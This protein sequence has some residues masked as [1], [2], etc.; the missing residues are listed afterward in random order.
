MKNRVG[1][2]FLILICVGLTIGLIMTSNKADKTNRNAVEKIQY[3][4]NQVVSTMAEVDKNKAVNAELESDRNK[5]ADVLQ[6]LT[7]L[8]TRTAA[9]LEKA[10]AD[11]QTA[12]TAQTEM[13]KQVAQRDAK[14]TELES[15]NQALDQRALELAT[16][17]TNLTAQIGDTQKKLATS[18]GNKAFLE[19]ELQR[20]MTEKADLERQFND[21]AVL[22]AQVSKLKTELNVS[23]RLE[24]IR[25]GLVP[26]GDEK[27]AE[28]LMRKSAIPAAKPAQQS[29]YD[30][31]VEVRSDGTVRVI[32]PT[33]NGPPAN[34][35]PAQ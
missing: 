10:Q 20:L 12:Q 16:S 9:N 19:K 18:E 5:Q 23:R 33:T 7:N 27:G 32:P 2:I 1:I 35:P 15:Q 17:I 24:W 22:R 8:Y 11:L 29:V 31:N 13:A 30:L 28:I 14:I 3:Y 25:K 6:N 21:L 4:S 26:A 34:P